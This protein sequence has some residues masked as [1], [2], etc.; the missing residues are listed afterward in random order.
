VGITSPT[1]SSTPAS[2]RTSYVSTGT[3]VLGTIPVLHTMED[4]RW[5]SLFNRRTA[6][7]G[8]VIEGQLTTG[9]WSR[10]YVRG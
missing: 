1:T 6:T 2:S 8:C 7:S 4:C 5:I 9:L 10:S 3:R